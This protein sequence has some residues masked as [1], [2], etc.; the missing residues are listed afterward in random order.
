[1]N[2]LQLES[3]NL[4]LTLLQAE[5]LYREE[6]RKKETEAKEPLTT[7]V[8]KI[9]IL[10]TTLPPLRKNIFNVVNIFLR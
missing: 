2:T 1:M 3:T 6:R 10:K 8:K 7:A 9:K 5:I 4:E